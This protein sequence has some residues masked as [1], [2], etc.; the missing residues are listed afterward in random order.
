MIKKILCLFLFALVSCGKE[1]T[2]SPN[3]FFAGE[4]VH[5]TNDYVVLYKGEVVIDSAKLDDNNRFTFDLDTAA[6]GLYHFYHN[7]ELQYV[8]LEKGDSLMVRLNTIDFDESLVFSGKGEE[9]NNFLLDL[10]LTDEVEVRDIYSKYYEMEPEDFKKRIDSLKNLK[11]SAFEEFTADIELSGEAKAL[12]KA[13][14]NY[15][16]YNYKERYPYEHKQRSREPSIHELPSNFYDYRKDLSYNEQNLN[17]LRPYYNFMRSHIENLTYTGCRHECTADAKMAKN[18]LH[19]N[20]HRMKLIDS[21]VQE[22]ELKD[23]LLRNVAFSYLLWAKDK[24]ENNQ[25][26]IDEFHNLSGNNRHIKEIDE[27]YYGINNIQPNKNIPD[28]QVINFAG[29]HVSMNDIAK[30]GKTVFYFWSGTEKKHFNDISKRVSELT[31]SKPEYHFVGISFKTDEAS[32]K[33]IL[34]TS[35][36]DASLQFRSD[37]FEEL[38]KALVIYPLNKCII[39]EDAKIVDGFATL[40]SS[41]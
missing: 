23:N 8:Y 26:F 25:V 7:P 6:N 11:L 22:K 31:K 5:P 17:Y 29:D 12:A 34:E 27:L 28:L 30:K 37:N 39:T 9:I 18:Q 32:W 40:Y 21:L 4:I 41:F 15:T 38:R 20:R 10:F 1:D 33:G 24:E 14:I 19:F 36:L 2:K 13:S 35:G 3:V 16:Y